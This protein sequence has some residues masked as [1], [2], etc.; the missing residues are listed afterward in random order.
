M[1]QF[2]RKILSKKECAPKPIETVLKASR[3]LF[4]KVFHFSDDAVFIIDVIGDAFIDVNLA[5]SEI[6]EYSREA[7]LPCRFSDIHPNDLEGRHLFFA[8]LLKSGKS[9]TGPL[10]CKKKT[11]QYLEVEI[12]ASI[13]KIDEQHC[14]IAVVRS[15]RELEQSTKEQQLVKTLFESSSD[16]IFVTDANGYIVK[17][18]ASFTQMTGYLAEDVI[19]KNPK[20]LQSG[21]HDRAFY[22]HLWDSIGTSG[23]WQG[24][25]WNR[26]KNGEIVPQWLTIITVKNAKRKVTEYI[27]LFSEIKRHDKGKIFYRSHFD[28][29][30]GLPN[31]ILISERLSQ[32]L[33]Q[34]R[35]SQTKTALLHIDLDGFRQINARIGH[36]LGDVLL[37]R[38]ATRLTACVS[39]TDTVGRSGE[40][41]F[42]IVTSGFSTREEV[43]SLA[44]KIIESFSRPFQI[45]RHEVFIGASLGISVCPGDT[46]QCGTL[47]KHADLAMAQAKVLGKNNYQFYRPLTPKANLDRLVLERDLS[48]AV[49]CEELI[50]HYQ[51]IIDLNATSMV[52]VEALIRWKHPKRGLLPPKEFIPLAE[53]SGLIHKIGKW[54]LRTACKEVRSWQNYSTQKLVLSVNVSPR[55]FENGFIV[56]LQDA[57]EESGLAPEWVNLEITENLMADGPEKAVAKLMLA[58]EMGV[59]LSIDDFG[60]G[61]SSLSYLSIL[62]VDTLKIDRS[63]VHDV[64]FDAKHATMVEAI[65]SMAHTMNLKVVAEGI[66]DVAELHFMKRYGTDMVQGYHLS[67]PLPADVL[68][69]TMKEKT[70]FFS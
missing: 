13:D 64:L 29:L 15:V 7:L 40:D 12:A 58:R 9:W 10:S 70:G 16:G 39:E 22:A 59:H 19:G 26:R 14:M 34:S 23:R 48:K 27:G 33:K 62:P 8:S 20:I 42:L 4:Y 6:L 36:L 69:K 60:T 5:A 51:P 17:V 3:D 30:T 11:G 54:V 68:L 65:I 38:I 57:L 66:E 49:E 45:D 24:E 18:N 47:L 21:R 41:E 43:G 52:G 28:P 44:G 1:T 63:F 50:L 55:Q 46:D 35:Q 67:H 56:V 53:E 31:H 2:S 32:A 37:Q 25:I 61:Y